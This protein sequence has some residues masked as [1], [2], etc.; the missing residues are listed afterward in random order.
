[1]TRPVNLDAERRRRRGRP[2]TLGGEL[3][4][5]C[6]DLVDARCT[7]IAAIEVVADH[8]RSADQHLRTVR[9]GLTPK[10]A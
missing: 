7:L 2:L 4:A 8:L 10:A 1:M 5:A 9:G 3:D 6:L